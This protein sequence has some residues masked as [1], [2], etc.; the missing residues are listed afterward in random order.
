MFKRGLKCLG[1]F[2]LALL[3]SCL[4]VATV[5]A[6]TVE[7]VGNNSLRVGTDI[8]DLAVTDCYT[9]ENVLAS[10]KRGGSQY[11]F[12]IDGRWYDLLCDDICSLGDM[13]DPNRA[14]PP[15]EVRAWQLTCWYGPEGAVEHFEP[16]TYTLTYSA[17]ANGSIEGIAIQTVEHGGDGT[18]VMAIAGAGCHFVRWSDGSTVNP[19]IDTGVTADV[20]VE[21]EFAVYVAK[22]N[23]QIYSEVDG[24]LERALLDAKSGD[25]VTLLADYTLRDSVTVPKGVILLL[26]CSKTDNGYTS[27]GFNPDGTSISPADLSVLFRTLIIPTGKT[28]TIKGTVLV[29]AVT[30]RPGGGHYD[31]DITGG[32]SQIDLSGNIVVHSGGLLDVFGK[33]TGDGTVE[34]LDGGSVGDLFVVRNWRG[35]TNAMYA[36]FRDI[37]PFN[38]YDLHNIEAKIIVNSGA[39]YYGNVKMYADE[40]FHCTRFYQFDRAKGLIKLKNGATATKSY[41]SAIGQTT[42]AI[43]GGAEEVGGSMR[44]SG[45]DVSTEDNFYPIDGHITFVLSNGD[46]TINNKV[47]FLPGSNLELTPDA[48]LTVKPGAQLV[49]YNEFVDPPNRE[50]TEYPERAPAT[51]TL[52]STITVEGAFAGLVDAGENARIIAD[53]NAA[54][55]V[56]SPEMHGYP[57]DP[58]WEDEHFITVTTQ[59]GT[60]ADSGLAWHYYP[61]GGDGN[62]ALLVAEVQDGSDYVDLGGTADAFSG[63]TFVVH[64]PSQ[65]LSGVKN[66]TRNRY[67]F[68]I[69]QAIALADS[70]DEIHVGEGMY[71]ES[72]AIDKS[73]TLIGNPGDENEHGAGLSQAAVLNGEG[74]NGNAVQVVG[75]SNVVIKGFAITNYG[76]SGVV[77]EGNADGTAVH[78]IEVS[79]NTILGMGQNKSG[80]EFCNVTN[81]QICNNFIASNG[82]GNGIKLAAHAAGVRHITMTGNAINSNVI[83]GYP[84]YGML[85]E[86]V[87]DSGTTATISDVDIVANNVLAGE[88]AIL[89]NTIGGGSPKLNSIRIAWSELISKE[90]VVDVWAK[91]ENLTVTNNTMKTENTNSDKWWVSGFATGSGNVSGTGVFSGNTVQA[92]SFIGYGVWIQDPGTADWI[93]NDNGLY[94]SGWYSNNTR[95]VYFY[96]PSSS[97]EINRNHIWNWFHG[98]QVMG[99][100]TAVI[101][102]NRIEHTAYGISIE[103]NTDVASLRSNRFMQQGNWS[104]L[105]CATAVI[106]ARYNYWGDAGGPDQYNFTWGNII[107][108]P[109]YT[110]EGCTQTSDG[111]SPQGAVSP[112]VAGVVPRGPK[113]MQ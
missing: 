69:Q 15:V 8:Y 19:R 3:L 112:L 57:K 95:G 9:Y 17:G 75:A 18:A 100:T 72:L 58:G 43:N 31:Q 53:A 50:N 65:S 40:K 73:I 111:S 99:D 62:T 39:S 64:E 68:T 105:N 16:V 47:K 70:G 92:D 41:N 88:R 96:P 52:D 20:S 83:E 45:N 71:N 61:T 63:Y 56:T 5:S 6:M 77:V 21:A 60:N 22:R 108:D 32:Y 14:V 101:D 78:D 104:L 1:V 89:L 34:A 106:D 87:A 74:I 24:G 54:L 49:L 44:I 107:L 51:F 10:L 97:V 55:V 12:K 29:N 13:A 48:T 59:L 103:G 11:Y 113:P 4:F 109:W 94:G 26:P 80:I 30:G 91:V 84:K 81:S 38:Q 23:D 85:I 90:T 98:V 110:D 25:K 42:V 46:Y 102:S 33:I 37:F 82:L 93:I 27:T 36:Y 7:E 35:G 2:T 67:Y 86:S 76:G 79:Y 66:F 28:M